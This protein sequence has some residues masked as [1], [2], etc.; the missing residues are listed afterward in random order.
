[1]EKNFFNFLF[2]KMSSPRSIF[3]LSVYLYINQGLESK[4]LFMNKLEKIPCSRVH[5][6]FMNKFKF[7]SQFFFFNEHVHEQVALFMNCS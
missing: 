3:L 2:K 1:M 6:R 7:F 4:F 5:E